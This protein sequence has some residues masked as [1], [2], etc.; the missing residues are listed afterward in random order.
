MFVAG[1]HISWHTYVFAR[2]RTLRC[3]A[4]LADVLYDPTYYEALL[5]TLSLVCAPHTLTYI[6]W[7]KRNVAEEAFSALAETFGFVVEQLPEEHL[8]EEY[9]EAAFYAVLRL[10]RLEPMD[11]E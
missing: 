5:K 7:K 2:Q 9:Q 3:T 8:A 10:A 11:V 6:G 1:R 4:L